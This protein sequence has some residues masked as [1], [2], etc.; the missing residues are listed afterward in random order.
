VKRINNN[1]KEMSDN[2]N[3]YPKINQT[4]DWSKKDWIVI[5]SFWQTIAWITEWIWNKL[6]NEE[7]RILA[8][9]WNCYSHVSY[10]E[11]FLLWIRC[12]ERMWD[13][14]EIL[15]WRKILEIWAWTFPYN[16]VFECWEYIWIDPFTWWWGWKILEIDWLNFLRWCESNFATIVSFWVIDNTIIVSERYLEEMCEEIRRVSDGYALLIWKDVLKY[17]WYNWL[18]ISHTFLWWLYDFRKQIKE[19][20]TK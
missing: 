6:S 4:W 17:F 16:S 14:P 15:K 11:S 20:H 18:I 3:E 10:L 13:I 5:P 12:S 9:D 19:T 7:A 1:Y 2:Q 8:F